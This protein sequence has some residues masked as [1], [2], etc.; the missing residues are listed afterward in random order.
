MNSEIRKFILV[1]IFVISPKNDSL[2]F[3]MKILEFLGIEAYIYEL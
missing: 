1:I 3:K 2:G